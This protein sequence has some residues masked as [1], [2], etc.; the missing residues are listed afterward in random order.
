[1]DEDEL[2]D[3]TQDEEPVAAG[4]V[5]GQRE[6]PVDLSQLSSSSEEERNVQAK[7]LE[8]TS[9]ERP[10]QTSAPT[11]ALYRGGGGISQLLQIEQELRKGLLQRQASS[12][13]FNSVGPSLNSDA[14][15]GGARER[16]GGDGD[17]DVA[18][19][20][21]AAPSR[22]QPAKR[23]RPAARAKATVGATT[24]GNEAATATTSTTTTTATITKE[25]TA[26]LKKV[27]RQFESEKYALKFVKVLLSPALMGGSIGLGI[28][29][30]FQQTASLAEH[31]RI[32]YEVSTAI[33]PSSVSLSSQPLIRWNRLVPSEARLGEFDETA[34]PFAM[35]CFDGAA[36]VGLIDGDTLDGS[37][38]YGI[39]DGIEG[40]GDG[41]GPTKIYVLAYRLE[42][43]LTKLQQ[44]GHREALLRGGTPALNV[45]NVRQALSDLVICR[46]N[47]E[48]LDASSVD[49]ASGHVVS[50]TKAIALRHCESQGC[51]S[52]SKFIAGKS[53]KQHRS[54]STLNE[55]LVKDP[56][57][58][59]TMYAVR[60][61]IA[62]PSVTPQ[63]SHTLVKKYGSLRGIYE[64]LE[65]RG[66]ST[67]GEAAEAKKKVLEELR[68]FGGQR[69][70]PV[71]AE[72]LVEFFLAEDPNVELESGR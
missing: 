24:A 25:E 54:G 13:P 31:E 17:G 1:M 45:E 53:K 51:S 60:A 9:P 43:H 69:V 40:L 21:A 41:D 55:L 57:P 71:A 56:L 35:L 72:S 7:E 18:A 34:E 16:G 42:Q 36:L 59:H 26:A 61:L 20:G 47:V 8:I 30:A 5:V 23:A 38:L 67:A 19:A 48:L 49:E 64:F 63:I 28:A 6:G 33:A 14:T 37:K 29:Q 3:L 2:V 27:R 58:E 39:L 12:K 11:K 32:S 15:G 22:V 66:G 50:V 68:T 44:Q 62:I 65:D 4:V 70:G 52:K 46:T 10:V